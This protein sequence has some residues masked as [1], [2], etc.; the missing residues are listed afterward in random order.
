MQHSTRPYTNLY[1]NTVKEAAISA[2]ALGFPADNQLQ[3]RLLASSL[4]FP[5]VARVVCQT[6][7]LENPAVR[8]SEVW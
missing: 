3:Q 2:M 7:V 5:R 6:K 4:G 1:E 8:V